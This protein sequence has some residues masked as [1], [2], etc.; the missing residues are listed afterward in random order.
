[1]SAAIRWPGCVCEGEPCPATPCIGASHVG[2]CETPWCLMAETGPLC[3]AC[4]KPKRVGTTARVAASAV[5]AE[6]QGELFGGS[7]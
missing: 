7:R 2:A 4:A 3:A 5:A 6:P 1:M